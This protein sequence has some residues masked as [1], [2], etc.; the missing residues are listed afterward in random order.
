MK[1][2]EVNGFNLDKI[3]PKQVYEWV[4]TGKWTQHQF[5]SWWVAVVDDCIQENLNKK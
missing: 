2:E 4:K 3:P 1:L 5:L